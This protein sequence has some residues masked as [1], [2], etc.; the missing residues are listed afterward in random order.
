MTF[1]TAGPSAPAGADAGAAVVD[2]APG[3]DVVGADVATA[4]ASVDVDASVDEDEHAVSSVAV[5]RVAAS[6]RP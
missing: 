3:A 1:C 6:R 2:V 4:A 5:A